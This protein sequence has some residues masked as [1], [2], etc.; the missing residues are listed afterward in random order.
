MNMMQELQS[1]TVRR[2]DC[3]EWIGYRNPSGY[4]VAHLN[5]KRVL[6]HRMSWSLINGP[7]P[8]GLCILHKCDT[9]AC[10]NPSHLFA[11][12]LL[13]NM[14]D[15]AAKG[16]MNNGN[17]NKTHCSRGHPFTPDN[18][19]EKKGGR[20]ECRICKREA[21]KRQRRRKAMRT[22]QLSLGI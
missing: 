10:V 5:R 15:C 11:G 3:W 16:R 8:A 9:R 22:D 4:G 6:A 2:G 18:T 21:K 7:V 12:T 14:R 20:R 1:K 13:E 17:K 19:K